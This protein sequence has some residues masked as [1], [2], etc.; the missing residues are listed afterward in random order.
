[1]VPGP[2]IGTQRGIN[3]VLRRLKKALLGDDE[4]VVYECRQCGRSLD[5]DRDR[6]PNCG[7]SEV[8]RF[9]L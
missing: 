8:A 9:T 1:M 6:C 7:A 5:A 2:V 3:D 4:R